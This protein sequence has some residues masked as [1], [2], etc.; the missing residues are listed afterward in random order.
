MNILIAPNSMK[1]SLSASKFANAIEKA[2][3]ET[4]PRFFNTKTFPVA[5]G[6]D[7]TGEILVEALGL[8][9]HT[10]IVNDPLGREIKA[11]LGYSNKIAVIEMANASGMK[12]LKNPELNPLKTSSYGT[13]QLINEAIK[14]GAK[15]IY[16]GV[17][18]SATVDG[19]MGMLEALGV[20]F[21]NKKR[22]L[23]SGNGGNL[24]KIAFIDSSN[25][26]LPESLEIKI[27]SDVDNPLLGKN[28]AA[29]IFGPQKG[30]TPVMVEILEKG[31]ANLSIILHKKT[32][33]NT[34]AVKGGGA[35]GGLAIGLVALLK[36]E[37]VDGANFILDLLSFENHLEWADVV[38][39]GEG[40][41]DKQSLNNKAPYAVALRAKKFQ[42]PVYAIVGI[43]DFPEQKIFKELFPLVNSEISIEEAINNTEK[44]VF[45]Q[46]KKLAN[47]LVES[48]STYN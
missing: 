4:D 15:K 12:L 47:K 45:D 3:L 20:G 38:I 2:F 17:G 40:K 42:K 5:D 27:I 18:G 34:S 30:A 22:E 25:L 41:F 21:F 39:T 6:G 35:A 48:N 29:R 28:G 31:L 36:A 26:K 19:G 16:L 14:F 44:L 9:Q 46:A 33:I 37:I 23:L 7:G 8:K 1:S 13:G 32:G 24:V 11:N 10:F 43:N